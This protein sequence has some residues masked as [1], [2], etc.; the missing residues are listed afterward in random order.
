MYRKIYNIYRVQDFTWFQVSTGSLGTYPSWIR[1][2]QCT[3]VFNGI[4]LLTETEHNWYINKDKSREENGLENFYHISLQLLLE[5]SKNSYQLYI[6]YFKKNCGVI[7]LLEI[8]KC[9]TVLAQTHRVL[10]LNISL[11]ILFSNYF[12]H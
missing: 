7:Y 9:S 3:Q 6:N 2:V 4:S 12:S 10:V 5:G 1:G 8:G 11:G